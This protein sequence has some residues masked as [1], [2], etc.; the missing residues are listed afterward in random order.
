ML[1]HTPVQLIGEQQAAPGLAEE[2]LSCP[3]EKSPVCLLSDVFLLAVVTAEP[4]D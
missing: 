2:V 1:S 3:E 4:R